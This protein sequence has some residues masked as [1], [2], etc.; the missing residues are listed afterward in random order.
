MKRNIKDSQRKAMFAHMNGA[1]NWKESRKLSNKFSGWAD[2]SADPSTW[3]HLGGGALAGP[4]VSQCAA[5]PG[6]CGIGPVLDPFPNA[7]SKRSK[8]CKK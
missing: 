6:V 3:K 4:T 1:L 2:E 5:Y 7:M 8:G